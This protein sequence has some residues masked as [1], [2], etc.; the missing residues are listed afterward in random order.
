[1]SE[2]KASS[3]GPEE[4]VPPCEPEH[5][6]VPIIR[7]GHNKFPPGTCNVCNGTGVAMNKE[8]EWEHCIWCNGTGRRTT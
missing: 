8:C 7:I 5:P 3:P 6:V 4:D 2:A 1:M